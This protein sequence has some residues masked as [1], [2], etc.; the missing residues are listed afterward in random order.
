M[1]NI[2][3]MNDV[4]IK[5]YR[6]KVTNSY[7]LAKTTQRKKVERKIRKIDD[8]LAEISEIESILEEKDIEQLTITTPKD[9]TLLTK[10]HEHSFI[11]E[12]EYLNVVEIIVVNKHHFFISLTSVN[13]L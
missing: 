9:I 3:K 6:M 10:K 5:L 12:G 11:Y 8:Y 4:S 2:D 7:K 13:A 1:S